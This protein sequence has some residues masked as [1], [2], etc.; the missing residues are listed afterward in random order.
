M[1]QII[2]KTGL[3][4]ILY[5]MTNIGLTTIISTLSLIN[6]T[7]QSIY[8][9]IKSLNDKQ[10]NNINKILIELD[11]ENTIKVINEILINLESVNISSKNILSNIQN[12]KDI[13]LKIE[14]ELLLL[15]NMVDYNNSIW[16]LKKYRSY[17]C[18]NILDNLKLY[19]SILDNRKKLLTEVLQ[20]NNFINNNINNNNI[21]NN[22]KD[23][24]NLNNNEIN[25]TDN[26]FNLT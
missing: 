12:I 11:L 5:A 13:I 9:L 20:I 3:G 25:I 6:K 7:S 17:D 15:H 4:I 8:D 1:K 19:K 23:N 26:Y 18:Q 16:I 22:N 14:N 10:D 21:K 2:I 24:L